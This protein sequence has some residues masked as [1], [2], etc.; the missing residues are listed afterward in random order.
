MRPNPDASLLLLCFSHAGGSSTNFQDWPA[1]LP[2]SVEVRPVQLPGRGTRLNEAPIPHLSILADLITDALNSSLDRPFAIFGHSMGA[3]LGFE[4][5][6]RLRKRHGLLPLHFFVLGCPAPQILDRKPPTYHLPEAEFLDQLVRLNGTPHEILT[7]Y[8]LMQMF[9]PMLKADFAAFETYQYVYDS[10]LTNPI[11]AFG[12]SHDSEA[13]PDELAAWQ[14]QTSASFELSM[15]A[16]GHFLSRHSEMV[17]LQRL[18]TSLK[19]CIYH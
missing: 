2:E 1:F 9:L 8:D 15:V 16:G 17:M 19:A 3:L 6:R 10:P 11:T 14:K 18:A 4:V 5:I 12:G 13:S 7:N